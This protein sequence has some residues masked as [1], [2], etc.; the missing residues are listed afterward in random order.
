MTRSASFLPPKEKLY[1]PPNRSAASDES[2]LLQELLQERKAHRAVVDLEHALLDRQRQRED[3][4]EAVADPGSIV[5]RVG[6]GELVPADACGDELEQLRERR[7]L[8]AKRDGGLGGDARRK[9]DQEAVGLDPL[10]AHEEA[11]AALGRGMSASMASQWMSLPRVCKLTSTLCSS[12]S[13][14]STTFT[15][16][17]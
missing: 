13:T 8:R 7:K 5:E 1:R 15:S 10:R 6:L 16:I 9:G 12:L 14:A 17:T 11:L 2:L 4:G 3:L